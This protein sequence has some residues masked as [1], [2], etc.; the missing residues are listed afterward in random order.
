MLLGGFLLVAAKATR[1]PMT[2]RVIAVVIFVAGVA[3]ALLSPDRAQ[4]IKDWMVG[5]GP[6]FFRIAACIPLA[7]GCF[8]A[9]STVT[10]RG[11]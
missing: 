2:V 4:L 1:T 3:T 7:V 6:D 9:G 5:R 8:I 11:G 10:R